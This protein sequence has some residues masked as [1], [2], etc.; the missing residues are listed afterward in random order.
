MKGRNRGQVLVLFALA[1]VVLIGMAALGIDVGYMYTV[2]HELQR[3]ADAGALAG[4][5]RFI[6]APGETGQWGNANVF[7]EATTRAVDFASKDNV[8]KSPLLTVAGDNIVVTFDQ[9]PDRIKV[10]TERTVP[11]FFA[12]L[13]LGA[14]KRISAFAVAEAASVSQNTTCVA[15][16]GIPIP[17]EER[18]GDPYRYD[19][20]IDVIHWPLSKE[21]LD[22]TCQGFDDSHT[23]TEW[24]YQAHDNASARSLRD[25][26]LCP[27]SLL[28]LK[29]GRPQETEPGWFRPL[30]LTSFAVDCPESLASSAPQLYVYLIKNNDCSSA[31]CRVVMNTEDPTEQLIDVLTGDRVGPTVQAVAP[32]YYKTV[33]GEAYPNSIDWDSLMD[34]RVDPTDPADYGEDNYTH[35]TADWDF[36]THSPREGVTSRRIIQLPIYDPRVPVAQGGQGTIQPVAFAGF[37]IQDVSPINNGQATITGR[38]IEVTGVGQG[39]PDPGPGGATVKILRLVE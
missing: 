25:A 18:G 23:Y 28:R 9:G 27:G 5:S 38:L 1:L 20:G 12:R 13:F 39:G 32:Q 33:L 3:C 35:S 4:A 36:T 6:N 14:T 10:Q 31:N 16:W 22:G 19:D 29:I 11:L 8:V 34:G 7:A 2:R 37:W 24:S 26:Y 21:E 15:P 17:W 30:D